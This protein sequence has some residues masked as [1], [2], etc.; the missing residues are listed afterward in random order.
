MFKTDYKK[1]NAQ[2]KSA[3]MTDGWREILAYWFLRYSKIS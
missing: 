1:K 2:K 3:I